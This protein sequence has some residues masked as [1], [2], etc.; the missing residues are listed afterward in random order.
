MC[1]HDIGSSSWNLLIWSMASIIFVICVKIRRGVVCAEGFCFFESKWFCIFQITVE[2]CM[3][4]NGNSIGIRIL[5][6]ERFNMLIDNVVVKLNQFS[7]CCCVLFRVF[8]RLLYWRQ[9]EECKRA[10]FLCVEGCY[11]VKVDID[12]F[13]VKGGKRDLNMMH[14]YYLSWMKHVSYKLAYISPWFSIPQV[15]DTGRSIMDQ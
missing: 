13:I 15:V 3:R 10:Y 12:N 11:F 4:I 6:L 8:R 7:D 2:V 14:H 9:V 5:G 1:W